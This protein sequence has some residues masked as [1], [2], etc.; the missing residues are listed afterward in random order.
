VSTIQEIE[1]AIRS[2]S[3]EERQR[4]AEDLPKLVP[5]M[6]GDAKWDRIIRDPRPRPALE[7]LL[8]E[9]EAEYE[10]H[11][12]KFRETSEEEFNRNS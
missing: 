8:D 5:E 4:L 3:P 9:V 2:L 1:A 6:D 11:P 7:K 10:K 12:E